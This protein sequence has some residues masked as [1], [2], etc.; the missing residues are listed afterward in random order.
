MVVKLAKA[1]TYECLYDVLFDAPIIRNIMIV[2]YNSGKI[3]SPNCTL[4]LDRSVLSF[5]E[6]PSLGNR[7][8][9]TFI[10]KISSLLVRL[11]MWP[12]MLSDETLSAIISNN[13]FAETP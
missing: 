11:F 9:G 12:L 8:C 2:G 3:R 1:R 10:E 4:R 6:K 5:F 7:S 13:V